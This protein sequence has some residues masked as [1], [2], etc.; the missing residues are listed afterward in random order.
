MKRTNQE[1][2][3]IKKKQS[4]I[5]IIEILYITNYRSR[6]KIR[7]ESNSIFQ[8]PFLMLTSKT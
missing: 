8:Y 2:D 4:G 1:E 6:K 5:M 3:R 7:K